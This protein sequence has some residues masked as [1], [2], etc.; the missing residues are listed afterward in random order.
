MT[1]NRIARVGA[2]LVCLLLVPS[3]ISAEVTRVTIASRG[4][5][6]GGRDFGSVGPYEQIVGRVHFSIDPAHEPNRVIVDLDK[7]PRNA[8]GR[9]ELSADLVVFK[10]RD[11]GRGNSVAL[12]DIVN[13]GRRTVIDGF[14]RPGASGTQSD[15]ESGD[16][17][18][19]RQGYTLVWIGW[20]FDLPQRDGAIRIEVPRAQG[21]RGLV[22][23]VLTPAQ[24]SAEAT[25]G[26]LAGYAPADPASA[27]NVLT[28]RDNLLAAPVTLARDQWR[29]SGN[30]VTLQ[31]GFEPGRTYE[32][33]YVATDSPVSGLGFAAVRD[34]A[35][36]IKYAGDAVANAKYAYAFG[37]SQSG[38]FLRDFLYQGFNSDERQRPVFDGVIAHIAGAAR[39]NLNQRWSTPTA[40]ATYAATSFP[41]ADAKQRDPVTGAEEGALDNP[42]AR[43]HQPKIFYT[44]TGVEYW[45]GGRSAALIHTTPDGARDVVPPDNVRVYFLAGTQ[46]GPARFPSTMTNGQQKDNP[47]DYWW[48]MRALLVAMDHWVRQGTAPP[49]SQYPR[50]ADGTLVRA[51][52]VAFPGIPRVAS[53]RGLAAGGRVAN[54]LLPDSGGAGAPLPLLVP[55]VDRDGN[56][57]AGIRLPDV[58]VPLGTLTGWNFRR[59]GIGAPDQLFPLLGSYVPFAATKA[60]RER[61]G[62]PRLSIAERYS[63]RDH[64]LKTAEAA[65]VALV[66]DGY[67]LKDDVPVIVRRAAEHWDLLATAGTSDKRSI[68]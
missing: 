2:T 34:T 30:T 24:K 60:D 4:G 23:A 10:P 8:A 56:E 16:G 55:Q 48:T 51:A 41:F 19:L 39:T 26:D 28:V 62:D 38:R 45:G 43:A 46:H 67:L 25:F 27:E 64:Y 52:E 42:R 9:V 18:L 17:F 65:G 44:N 1:R 14:N 5:V 31:G 36:W 61:A 3:L 49:A 50:L 66:K 11:P 35:A 54:R 32:L 33:A 6:A 29:L 37:S 59:V 13:R 20:E 53:P 68:P 63:S 40:V 22:R 7:A 21:T 15:P 47:T 58:S 57:K 12:V